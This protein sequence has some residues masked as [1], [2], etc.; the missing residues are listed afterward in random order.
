MESRSD[1]GR[2]M[3]PAYPDVSKDFHHEQASLRVAQQAATAVGKEKK[4]QARDD[5]TTTMTISAAQASVNLFQKRFSVLI[6]FFD[7]VFFGRLYHFCIVFKS[8]KT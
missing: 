4:Q 2:H 5:C 1:D 3:R 8:P 6:Y 7:N